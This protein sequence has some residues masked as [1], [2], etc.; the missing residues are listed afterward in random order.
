MSTFGRFRLWTSFQ[1]S[2]VSVHSEILRVLSYKLLWSSAGVGAS[3]THR[4]FENLG[5][6]GYRVPGKFEKLGTALMTQNHSNIGITFLLN[7]EIAC[8]NVTPGFESNRFD[9]LLVLLLTG[10]GSGVLGTW[11]PAGTH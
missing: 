9:I 4:N 3:G 7:C 5:T 2:P 10:M 6:A 11:E 8:L 1:F